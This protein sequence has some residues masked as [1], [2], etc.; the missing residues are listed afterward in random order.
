[1]SKQIINNGKSVVYDDVLSPDEHDAAWNHIQK[2][3][4]EVPNNWIKVWRANDGNPLMG[5]SYYYSKKPFNNFLDQFSEHVLKFANDHADF[6][7]PWKDFSL[8][9]Y[10]YPRNTKLSW[11]D[12]TGYTAAM[13]FYAHKHWGSTWGGELMVAETPPV[14]EVPCATLSHQ[15]EDRFMLALGVG[16]YI[17]PKPNR[18]V[19]SKSGTWHCINRVDQD[20]GDNLRCSIVAFFKK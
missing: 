14:K 10:I 17:L 9:S 16:H 1:M 20:A 8:R 19:I 2:D 11:H 12:D 15:W 13:V 4:Y 7:G 18:M 6:I 5:K 3:D